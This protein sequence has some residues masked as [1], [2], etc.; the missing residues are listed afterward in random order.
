MLAVKLMLGLRACASHAFVRKG[1]LHHLQVVQTYNFCKRGVSGK[2]V[3]KIQSK[4]R[5]QD[6]GSAKA[7]SCDDTSSFNAF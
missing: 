7:R 6:C 1:E 4:T 3:I 5:S 2:N